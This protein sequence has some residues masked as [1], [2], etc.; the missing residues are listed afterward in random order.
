[1]HYIGHMGREGTEALLNALFITDICIDFPE[2]T[3][4]GIIKSRD[5]KSGLSHQCQKTN[6]LKR[7]CFSTCVWASYNKKIKRFPK[8]DINR[9]D[10]MFFNQWMAR[11][12]H[13][14]DSITVET[15]FCG[16]LRFGQK[17]SCKNEIQFR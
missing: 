6:C 2:Y 15:G 14:N 13:I 9:N 10:L 3:E 16:I 5:M 4:S 11:L 1:M 7:Y 12:F 17:R 8:S